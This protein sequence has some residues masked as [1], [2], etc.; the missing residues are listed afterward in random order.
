MRN[1]RIFRK[2]FIGNTTLKACQGKW[3]AQHMPSIRKKL[4][5]AS[6]SRF[7]PSPVLRC[8]FCNSLIAFSTFPEP[9]RHPLIL[10]SAQKMPVML[11]L[12]CAVSL[13]STLQG[14]Q[15]Q[16]VYNEQFSLSSGDKV[17]QDISQNWGIRTGE[18]C[19]HLLNSCST[20]LMKSNSL[21]LAHG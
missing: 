12:Y 11:F 6:F 9:V 21:C 8:L 18:G 5:W 2:I 1:T 13:P 3:P 19:T 16:E 20:H 4:L 17:E 7:L 14:R 10:G 15:Q